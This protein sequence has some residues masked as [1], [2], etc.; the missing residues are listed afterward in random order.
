MKKFIAL[1][2]AAIMC[3]SICACGGNNTAPETEAPTE[4]ELRLAT[5]DDTEEEIVLTN[6]AYAVSYLSS[7]LKN[8]HSIE[9]Y[10]IKSKT[11]SGSYFYVINYSAENN[12]GGRIEDTC[13]IRYSQNK[14]GVLS[15]NGAGMSFEDAS[16]DALE[17]YNK[18]VGA[19]ET[20]LDVDT[21]MALFALI[22]D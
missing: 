9:V 17:L 8:P 5:T 13:C 12:V 16:E 22:S 10:S 14:I 20:K 2:L 6:A 19:E 15:T 18:F 1:L 3:L 7:F 21:V 11:T 4:A